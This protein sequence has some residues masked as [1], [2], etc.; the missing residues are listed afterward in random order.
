[1]LYRVNRAMNEIFSVSY[2]IYLTIVCTEKFGSL[3]FSILLQLQIP[4]YLEFFFELLW[5]AIFFSFAQHHFRY[6]KWIL[7]L[8][9]LENISQVKRILY[10][11]IFIYCW[12]SSRLINSWHTARWTVSNNQLINHTKL[13]KK[14]YHTVRTVPKFNRKIIER[15]KIHTLNKHIQDRSHSWQDTGTSVKGDRV[16]LILW[17]QISSLSE[18]MRSCKCF[19]MWVKCE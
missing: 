3:L 2:A 4:W 19:K 18:M 7:T 10:K 9:Y 16:E 11:T 8:I 12:N 1:M 17:A 14:K 13:R 5:I 15:N 6:R